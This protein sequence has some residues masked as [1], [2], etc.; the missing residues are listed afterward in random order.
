M[1]TLTDFFQEDCEAFSSQLLACESEREAETKC[2]E[3]LS[4]LLFPDISMPWIYGILCLLFLST[5]SCL[6][7]RVLKIHTPLLRLLLPA[8]IGEWGVYFAE[9]AAWIGAAVLLMIGYYHRLHLLERSLRT[10][11][12]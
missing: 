5:A 9:I 7:L 10:E 1:K 12:E 2:E 11:N 6:L 4:R 8:L 3:E